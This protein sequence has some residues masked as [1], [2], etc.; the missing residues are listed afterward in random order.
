MAPAYC[1]KLARQFLFLHRNLITAYRKVR[2]LGEIFVVVW[3]CGVVAWCLF[4]DAPCGCGCE[5]RCY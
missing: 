4:C 1:E 3:E 2:W 5:C